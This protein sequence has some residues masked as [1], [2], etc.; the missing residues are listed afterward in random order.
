MAIV[1][2]V[3]AIVRFDKTIARE[4]ARQ[5]AKLLQIVAARIVELFG[6]LAFQKDIEGT[7]GF[8]R[9]LAHHRLRR[10]GSSRRSRRFIPNP[11]VDQSAMQMCAVHIVADACV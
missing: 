3:T 2:L 5:P 8:Y 6:Q 11:E 7:V 10:N 1:F 4:R 9:K